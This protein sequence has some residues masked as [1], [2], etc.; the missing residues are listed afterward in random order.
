MIEIW[1]E[2]DRFKATNKRFA[3]EVRTIAK[4]GWFSD[5]EI[6]EIHQQIYTQIHQQTHNTVTERL[7]T[8]K[9][10]NPNQTLHHNDPY[11]ANTQT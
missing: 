4:N 7:N 2:F 10:E 11:T 3:D 9:P 5:L 8:G 1:T 6:Q